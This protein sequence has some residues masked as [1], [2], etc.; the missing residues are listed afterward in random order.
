MLTAMPATQLFEIVNVNTKT[1]VNVN[2]SQVVNLK[3]TAVTLPQALPDQQFK[4]KIIFIAAKAV[5]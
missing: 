4:G 2:E 5:V 1:I 3:G